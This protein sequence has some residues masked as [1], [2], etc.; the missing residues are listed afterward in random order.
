MMKLAEPDRDVFRFL[1]PIDPEKPVTWDNVEVWRYT[2]P[3][4]GAASSP[5]QLAQCI[6]KLL[7]GEQNTVAQ[8][9]Q[10]SI[11]AEVSKEL[12][13]NVFV[14]NT[15]LGALDPAEAKLKAKTSEL[16][17]KK[18][19]MNLRDHISNC[20][21]VSEF[22]NSTVPDIASFLGVKWKPKEDVI[23][24]SIPYS[25]TVKKITKRTVLSFI[26]SIFDPM[27]ILAPVVFSGK[28]FLHS[29]WEARKKWD[30]PLDENELKQWNKFKECNEGKQV[31]LKRYMLTKEAVARY[32]H[33]FVDASD[34]GIAAVAFVREELDN[35]EFRVSLIIC[36]TRIAPPNYA[37]TPRLELMAAALGAA[38]IKFLLKELPFIVHSITLWSDSTCVIGWLM[39]DEKQGRFIEN[40]KKFILEVVVDIRHIRGPEN[41]ADTASRGCKIDELASLSKWW[42]GPKWLQLSEESWPPPTLNHLALEQ[43]VTNPSYEYAEPV[44]P[45]LPLLSSVPRKKLLN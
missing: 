43:A 26:A 37:T 9:L 14:D 23:F 15:L 33:V 42:L 32:L 21:E 13:G 4:F 5:F 2:R 20:S 38:L 27:G 7:E 45:D 28:V 25:K 6:G 1:L 40:R 16:I 10:P 31:Q 19:N 30:T 3:L 39:S 18:A 17:F 41:P 44:A 22:M 34:R 24:I 12:E 8:Q 29:L 36:K 11:F 35:G